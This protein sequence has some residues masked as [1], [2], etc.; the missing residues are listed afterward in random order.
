MFKN[1]FEYFRNHIK[2]F[3]SS[4]GLVL[5]FFQTTMN[6]ASIGVACIFGHRYIM[7]DFCFAQLFSGQSFFAVSDV[8]FN[9]LLH[10]NFCL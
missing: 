1:D 5:Q 7:E 3:S 2:Q 4:L 9:K 8:S 6:L 10:R